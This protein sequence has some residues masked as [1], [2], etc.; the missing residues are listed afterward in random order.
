MSQ[1]STSFG[2]DSN[3]FEDTNGS[4]RKDVTTSCHK[5]KLFKVLLLKTSFFCFPPK[6][7]CHPKHAVNRC[8][9]GAHSEL[10]CQ[11]VW[12]HCSHIVFHYC[13]YDSVAI[14]LVLRASRRTNL[15]VIQPSNTSV[16]QLH[17][18]LRVDSDEAKR[19]TRIARIHVLPRRGPLQI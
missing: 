2:K 14:S 16:T 4:A 7:L 12:F 6:S 17:L 8:G 10:L 15:A 9:N 3:P 11:N 13:F 18:I 19:Y 1:R 5:P